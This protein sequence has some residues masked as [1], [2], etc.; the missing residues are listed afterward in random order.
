M[1]TNGL[2]AKHGHEFTPPDDETAKQLHRAFVDMMQAKPWVQIGHGH[3][4]V[5]HHPRYGTTYTVVF[6]RQRIAYGA[7]IFIG[8]VGLDNL[9]TMLAGGPLNRSSAAL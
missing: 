6:G 1:T 8:D 4:I 5:H 7:N 3:F 2:I 9:L